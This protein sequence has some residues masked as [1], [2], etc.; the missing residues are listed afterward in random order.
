MKHAAVYIVIVLQNSYVSNMWHH[1]VSGVNPMS[2]YF[3]NEFCCLYAPFQTVSLC[4]YLALPTLHLS[5]DIVDFGTCFVG[6]T[7][8]R[9]VYL[10][11]RG[12][13]CSYWTAFQGTRKSLTFSLKSSH[14]VIFLKVCFWFFY[15]SRMLDYCSPKVIET[16]NVLFL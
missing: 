1:L 6:Q 3:P 9:E 16:K 10:Y 5:S 7:N 4:A 8:I 13:S 12:E 11:N 14:N 2:K 15:Q